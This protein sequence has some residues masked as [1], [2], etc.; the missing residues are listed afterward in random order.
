MAFIA[1]NNFPFIAFALQTENKIA[2]DISHTNRKRYE[3]LR[4]GFYDCNLFKMS[5]RNIDEGNR[6]TFALADYPTHS[7]VVIY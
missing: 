1:L 3:I 5:T 2:L 6:F 4:I 7:S